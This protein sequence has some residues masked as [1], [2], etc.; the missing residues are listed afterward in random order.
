MNV[1]IQ[2]SLFHN[3]S[4][5]LNLSSGACSINSETYFTDLIAYLVGTAACFHNPVA[6]EGIRVCSY[7]LNL[8]Y[9]LMTLCLNN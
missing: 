6:Y 3:F 1:I 2:I 9:L 7:M 8:V 5:Y 4:T